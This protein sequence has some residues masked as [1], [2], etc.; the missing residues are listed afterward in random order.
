VR[1]LHTK[2]ESGVRLAM[3][4]IDGEWKVEAWDSY[5]P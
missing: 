3:Q 1:S 5:R 2:G 4:Q